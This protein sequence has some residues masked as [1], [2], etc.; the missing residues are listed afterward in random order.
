MLK[1]V[2]KVKKEIDFIA[3]LGSKKIYIQSAFAIESE[4][5]KD[6]EYS[7]LNLTG[8]SFSKIVVRNDVAKS[9][10]DDNGVLTI[11][12]IDFLLGEW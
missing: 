5:K 10:Y 7:P 3:T 12:V 4:D 8:D 9:W 1:K 11:N 6:S 2:K